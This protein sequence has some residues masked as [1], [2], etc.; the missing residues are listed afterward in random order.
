M[1]VRESEGFASQSEQRKKE[2]EERFLTPVVASLFL[3]ERGA[4]T[5]FHTVCVH[6][7]S[8]YCKGWHV[9]SHQRPALLLMFA[10]FMDLTDCD[11]TKALP[12]S[13]RECTR[14]TLTD[15]TS[16]IT[17]CTQDLAHG[18]AGGLVGKRPNAEHLPWP[19]PPALPRY[20]R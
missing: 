5:L 16:R 14:N 13:S 3:C 1:D 7:T 18:G 19:L 17:H 8:P 11:F 2:R 10:Y 6:T 12:C 20:F 15:A 9:W 4:R